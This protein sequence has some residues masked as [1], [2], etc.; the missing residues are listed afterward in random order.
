MN[1]VIVVSK[2]DK[3]PTGYL[4]HYIGRPNVLGNPFGMRD[5]GDRADVVRWYRDWLREQWLQNGPSREALEELAER[6]RDGECIAL[7]CWCAPRACHGDV[8]KEAI[9]GIN[10]RHIERVLEK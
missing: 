3:E 8:I 6:V 2:K 1:Q 10:R 5:E 7:Q 4:L 9:E